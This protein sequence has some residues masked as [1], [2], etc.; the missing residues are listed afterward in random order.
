M[1]GTG[2]INNN[3]AEPFQFRF[4]DTPSYSLGQAIVYQMQVNTETSNSFYVNR[5]VTDTNE[6]YNYRARCFTCVTAIEIAA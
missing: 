4:V 3:H 2:Q 1:L 5:S 6:G